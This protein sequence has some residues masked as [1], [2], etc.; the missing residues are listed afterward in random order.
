MVKNLKKEDIVLKK[1][2]IEGYKGNYG[3]V[4]VVGGSRGFTGAPI[5]TTNSAVRSGAGLV[6][7]CVE[8]EI[9]NIVV[10]NLLEA[11]SCTFSNEIRF[12][13]LFKKASVVAIGP[14]MGIENTL[15]TLKSILNNSNCPLVIDADGINVLH[16]NMKLLGGKQVVLTPHLG[17]FS[18]LIG[19]DIEEIKKDKLNIV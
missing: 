13:N 8:D 12:R 3:H 6:T 16:K 11:M 19:L 9:E 18:R 4:I 7:L 17:E 10:P 15:D 2:N 5:I 14:G 1:R